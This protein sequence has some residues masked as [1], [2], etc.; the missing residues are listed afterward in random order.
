LFDFPLGE[1]KPKNVFYVGGIHLKE[2][3]H[4]QA[5]FFKNNVNIIHVYFENFL[6]GRHGH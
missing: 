6:D 1:N 4:E 5:R 3:K 2:Y